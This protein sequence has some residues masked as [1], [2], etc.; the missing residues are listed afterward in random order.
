[1]L[2]IVRAAWRWIGLDPAEIVAQNAFGNLIVRDVGGTFWRI[3]PEDLS[4]EIVAD[5]STE[6]VKLR[7]D[8]NFASDWEMVELVEIAKRIFGEQPADRC[9]C[10]K[11]PAVLGGQYTGE[12][13]GT[14]TREELIAFAGHVAE[15]IKDLPDGAGVELIVTGPTPN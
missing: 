12:N 10:L 13:I 3:C 1:M 14:I 11:M 9:F 15:Q 7:S 5:T 4:C 2:E 8:E 6:Y